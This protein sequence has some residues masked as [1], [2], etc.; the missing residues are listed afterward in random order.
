MLLAAFLLLAADAAGPSLFAK[1]GRMIP[2][3]RGSELSLYC[4]G[5]GL[6]VVV[7]ESG[8]GG[9][10]ASTW[11]KLQPQLAQSSRVCSYDRAGYGFSTLGRNLP[12]DLEHMVRD[13]A[14]MLERS[15][16]PAPY[17]LAGHSNGG[18]IVGAYANRY[19][20]R[21]AGLLFLDAAVTLEEDRSL[22]PREPLDEASRAHLAKI[23]RCLAHQDAECADPAWYRD[24]PADLAEAELRNLAKQDYWR[25]YLSEAEANYRGVLSAQARALLPRRWT[26]IPVRVFATDSGQ[27]ERQ[28][29]L[30]RQARLCQGLRDCQ[31]T[32]VPTSN[33]LVHDEAAEAIAAT[34]R[35][36][37]AAP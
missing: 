25:A 27:P 14:T 37:P 16:E 18:L 33:H 4:T 21:V 5:Q 28:R 35:H 2:V 29:F 34:V 1:P 9:G 11:R 12:R 3:G 7:L 6:P 26:K 32:R 22:P 10:T 20:D 31:L 13:L 15:G 36:W 30:D 23:R 24:F 8:F 19:P 17:L